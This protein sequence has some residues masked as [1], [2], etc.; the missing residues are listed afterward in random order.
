MVDPVAG[1]TTTEAGATARFTVVLTSQPV[2]DVT[3]GLSSSNVAE[4]TVSPATL[5]FTPT[6]W[7]TPQSATITGVNDPIDDGDIAF[8]ILTAAAASADVDYDGRDPP[9]VAVTNIDDDAAGITISPISGNTTEAGGT[10]TFSVALTSQPTANVGLVLSSSDLT[11]GTAGPASLTFTTS[12]WHVPQTVTVTG[13]DDYLD[14]GDIVY[15]IVTAPAASADAV[16]DG[17]NPADVVVSNTD[18]DAAGITL[19]PVTGLT[20]TEAGETATFTVALT[21]QPTAGVVMGLSSSDPTEGMVSP[22]NLTFKVNNW[23]VART[24]TVTGVDDFLDDGDIAYTI[25]TAPAASADAVYHGMNP[26]DVAVTNVDNDAPGITVSPAAGLVTTEAGGTATFTVAL[27]SQPSADVVM[28]LSSSDPSEGAVS[29]ASLTFSGANWNVAQTVTVTGV[30]DFLDDGNIAYTIVTAAAASADPGY[31][32]MNAADVGV[33]NTDNDAPRIVVNPVVGLVTTEAGGTATF[34]VVLASQPAADVVMGL[35][36]A[37]PTE[38]TVSPASLTF[39][40]LNWNV[41]QTVTV[42]G[43]DD[44][45]DDGNVIYTIMTGV[46]A[47]ADAGYNGLNPAD[48]AVTNTDNDAAGITVNPVAGLVTTEAGGTATFTVVLAS[49]P[50]ANVS[51]SLSS[52]D[53]TEGTVSPVSLTF[54]PLN[55]NVAQTVTVTGVDDVLDDGN[56]TYS[57]PT[58]AATSADPRYNG[59]N[60]ANVTV[61][62]TDDDAAGITVSAISGNT[63]EARGTAT[64]TV[65]LASQ[66]TAN[67]VMG[68]SSTDPS[69]GIVSPASL[70]FTP[71]NWNVA[72]TVTVTGVD[73]FL[74]DGNITYTIVTAAATSADAGYH[75]MNPA[76]VAV[77]NADDDAAGFTVRPIS[78]NTTEA[79]GTATFT[80]ALTSQPSAN[81]SVALSSSDPSEGTVSPA[82]LTFTSTA[83]NLPQTVTAT[84]VDDFLDDGD[85]AYT[86]VTAAATSADAGYDGINPVDVAVTNTDDDAPGIMVNPAAGLVTTEAGGTA[87]FTVRL[88]SQP[89]ASVVVGLSSSD[90]SEGTVTPG[91]LTFTTVNWNAARTVTVSGVDDY[92]D[93]GDIVYTIVTA[94]AASADAVY[95]G[96]NPADVVVSNTDDDAAGIT[97]SPVAGLT[98]TEAGGTATFTVVLTSQPTAGVVM[99]LSSSDPTEGMVSPGNLTFTAGNW[100]VARTVTVTGVDDFLDDGD[101][102]YTIV[103]APAA[104]ADAVYHGMNP[105]DVAVTNVDNDAPG[106][107]VSPAAG[108][109]T[110]EAGGTATFT[111][112]LTS[113]PSAD[114]VMGLSSSDPSEGAVSPASLTF[115]GA[116]WNVAQTVTVTGV[117]D[118]LDDG[119]IAYTIVTAAAASAD[120]GYD[121]MNA[122]D[123]GVTSQDNDTGPAVALELVPERARVEPGRPV[124]YTLAIR[125]HTA[126]DMTSVEIQHELPPRFAYLAGSAARDGRLIG[127]PAGTRVQQFSLDTLP[128]FADRNGDEVPGPGEHGYTTLSWTLVP[129]ASATPGAY[130]SAAVAVDVKACSTCVVSNR[131]EASVRVDEDGVFSRGTILGRVFDDGNRDG[132]QDAGEPGVAGAIVALDDGTWVSTDGDGRFHLPDLEAGPRV[133]KLDLGRLGIPATATTDVTQVVAVSPG[134]LATARFGVSFARDTVR[135][136]EPA[137]RGLAIVTEGPE[138]AVHVAGNVFRSTVAVDGREVAVRKVDAR[139]NPGGAGEVLRLLDNRLE[140]PATFQTEVSDPSGARAWWLEIRNGG[141]EALR[142]MEGTGVPPP[143][144]EWDGH[145]SGLQRLHGGEVYAYQLGVAFADGTVVEG[146]RRAFGV[147][148]SPSIALTLSG[149]AFSAGESALVPAGRQALSRLARTIRTFPREIVVIEGH[150]DSVGSA[151]ANLALSRRRATAV[152][153]FLVGREGILR[154]RLLVEAYGERRPV[155]SNGTEDGR[156]LN[157]RIEVY[158]LASEVKRGRLYHVFRG[159][160]TARVGK[161]DV[162]VDSAGDFACRVPLADNDTIEVALANRQ[163]R[164]ALARLR[165]PRLDIDEPRGEARIPFGESVGSLRV[166]PDAARGG[167]A[168]ALASLAIAGGQPAVAHVRLR[169]RTD[170]GNR[171]DVDGRAVPVRSDGTFSDELALHVG[172]NAFE[173]VVRDA[174]GTP[175]VARLV[176]RALDRAPG[177]GDLLSV[178]HDADFFVYLPRKGTVLSTRELLLAGRARPGH[179]VLANGDTLAVE[180]GGTFSGRVTLPEGRS[181]LR[182]TVEDPAGNRG[183]IE[184]EVEVRSQRLFLV[185][186]ADGVVGR[187]R[188]GAFVGAGG[189]ART[190]TEG[191]VA[192]QLKGWIG[193]RYLIS[194]AFDTRRRDFGS[195]F[196]DLDD[197]GR[198]RLLVNLDPDRLYPVFGDSAVVAHDAPGGGRFFLGVEGDA[199]RAS[200]GDFPI[201]FDEVEL[202]TFHRTLYGAQLRLGAP[203]AKTEQTR[204]SSL[205]LFG[206]QARYVQVRD[207]IRATGGTLYYLSHGDVIEGSIQVALVVHDRDTGL[208]LRRIA[209]QRGRD[210]TAKEL[211]GRVLFARP[212]SSV[213]EDGSLVDGGPLIGHPVTIEVDY[214]TRGSVGEKA[215]LGARARQGLGPLS[216]GA[217]VVDDR[218]GAGRYQ[219]KGGD[220]TLRL[221]AQSRLGFELAE[222]EGRAG[223]T[224][225]SDDGGLAFAPAD[226]AIV[227]SGRAWKVAAELDAGEWL[228][229]PGRIQLGG[230]VR[231]A[232]AGF[233]SEDLRGGD[234]LTQFGLRGRLD[235]R[236]WGVWS[237]RFDRDERGQRDSTGTRPRDVLGLQWRRDGR[238]L[239]VTTEFEQRS[240]AGEGAGDGSDRSIGGL[241]WWRPL[242]RLRTTLERQQALA[243]GPG[244]RT[245]LGLDWQVLPLLSLGTRGAYG[246]TG[247]EL[248]GDATLALGRHSAYVREERLDA[249]GRRRSGTLVGFQAPLGPSGRTYT[250]YQWQRDEGGERALSVLGIEQGWRHAVGVAWRVA[251]EHGAR[252]GASAGVADGERTTVS[253]DLSYRGGLPIRGTTR[254]EFRVDRGAVRQQQILVSTHVDWTLLAGF[255]LRGDYRSS[256]SRLVG[257]GLTP[258]RFEERSVGLAY[259]PARSDRVQAL[260]RWTRLTDRRVQGPADSLSSE[261]GFDVAALEASVRLSRGLEWSGKGAA[262]VL[263]EAR[264]GLPSIATHGAL[265]I[266]RLDYLVLRPVRFGMEYRLLTQRETADKSSGWLQE[267]SW[268]PATHLRFGLGYNFTRFSG[269]VLDREQEDAQGWF[270][271]A[272]S[273]Y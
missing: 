243:G 62:N 80:V 38:G 122:A 13:V 248:R 173:L 2:G 269:D 157:S 67:V 102:A 58:A 227:R 51:L 245:A 46:A 186:L 168:E 200:V 146:P 9:D 75:G 206:A 255:E 30:D 147:D 270:L 29:P 192:Y 155:A 110:T 253:S 236:R 5:T 121:G 219:L 215:A 111:V 152:R 198:D 56:V 237:T 261:S 145:L 235:G 43:V 151:E 172:E 127:D 259:R 179:R 15:T 178:E 194:S 57:I 116:N 17:M 76:D 131:A 263:R 87:T 174:R 220:A 28:G 265:W 132:R 153:D 78:G 84:G 85:I 114:V 257:R 158:G 216:L 107:T 228:R 161:L 141:N 177:G 136:A 101:I 95:D 267:F 229:H 123:V 49:Q 187:A 135:F 88:T 33:T 50:V 120:P 209:L 193:G 23:N 165:V 91:S 104:S 231:Q 6:D 142:R 66:P 154:E 268:D 125:N 77:T 82:S 93:D 20:T 12:N 171:L 159:T 225:A 90:P 272:Q 53:A 232:D 246:S 89:T 134:L 224:F 191:R 167:A 266:N 189:G 4:G 181:L 221:G 35:A 254:G 143:S 41:A 169:G 256:L 47:S 264:G 63:T 97:V 226:T 183:L 18:D 108:L 210:Y 201:A 72:Q 176:V 214:E 205:A 26:V 44:F 163:G 10:A 92:L 113:Q 119:N 133:L 99:G 32:G 208:P 233:V 144:V 103:T 190:W 258:A 36:S 250:E 117:D 149:D 180:A 21:S 55:W 249:P 1:L 204:G 112:A 73:D 240:S 150:T 81:V 129:G 160:A 8:T 212:I 130:G 128:A 94:P 98:T 271:R 59:V 273:R 137:V 64:F 182:V 100:N 45:L 69:E 166:E 86:I 138:R 202:A 27:T 207:A 37:D 109:V 148:H 34:T 14:D 79:G 262:R 234:A 48:V 218:S 68:L 70:T 241:L 74:D 24:V 118:F 115:S 71:L 217:T 203:A 197:A 139:L 244:E 7:A 199:L 170:P 164:T 211:E 140:S 196:R 222:S 247:R 106:I 162:P 238:R 175:R 31:H 96:M 54:T 251:G 213:W 60:P 124:R 188:G 16:Y 105:V 184:R 239:G 40:A 156:E 19:T 52:S 83:W 65:V 39:T 25:V 195:L 3:I 223:R 61:T 42:T 242:D 230:Y 22:G 185:A 260:G 126:F 11:E 252:P